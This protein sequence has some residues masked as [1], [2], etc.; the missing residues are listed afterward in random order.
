M[1]KP[2]RFGSALVYQDLAPAPPKRPSSP[3]SAAP[4]PPA[5]FSLKTTLG[6][7]V[8]SAA[9]IWPRPMFCPDCSSPISE[10]QSDR[11]AACCG[12]STRPPKARSR[13]SPL[14]VRLYLRRNRANGTDRRDELRLRAPEFL[15]PKT[16][17]PVV[18]HIDAPGICGDWLRFVVCHDLFPR[19]WFG[20]TRIGPW[21]APMQT[22]PILDQ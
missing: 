12:T 3:P 21:L 4:T 14:Q 17:L 16:D 6:V 9:T 2:L 22:I 1:H 13:L 15:R 18:A 7:T 11:A 8:K 20:G 5:L 10:F 19:Y